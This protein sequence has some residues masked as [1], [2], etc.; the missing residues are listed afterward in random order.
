MG[1]YISYQVTSLRR[2]SSCR[3]GDATICPFPA[4]QSTLSLSL[5]LSPLHISPTFISISGWE[6]LFS[7]INCS[8]EKNF[9]PPRCGLPSG[10]PQ[11]TKRLFSSNA[12]CCFT[13][14]FGNKNCCFFCQ[15]L[16]ISGY[17]SNI[18]KKERPPSLPPRPPSHHFGL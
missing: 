14:F 10:Y 12:D 15:L 3:N 1:I 4:P 6:G 17:Y 13:P 7:K 9:C 11:P 8:W 2:L 5:P 18:G 16:F